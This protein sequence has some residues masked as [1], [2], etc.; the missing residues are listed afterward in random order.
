[1]L[2]GHIAVEMDLAKHWSF[3][4]PVYYSALNFFTSDMKFRTLCFQ[5]EVRYWLDENNQ[6]WFGGAHL[7]LAWFNYAKGENTIYCV[8][9]KRKT[10]NIEKRPLTIGEKYAILFL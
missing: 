1:M 6:G 9:F 4:L 2:I 7:G 3:A 8:G 5:P 10:Q